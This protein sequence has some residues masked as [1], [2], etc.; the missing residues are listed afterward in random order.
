MIDRCT[1]ISQHFATVAGFTGLA[2]AQ[3]Q[4]AFQLGRPGEAGLPLVRRHRDLYRR[5]A[6]RLRPQLPTAVERIANHA[7][8]VLCPAQVGMGSVARPVSS[9]QHQIECRAGRDATNLTARGIGRPFGEGG[10]MIHAP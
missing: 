6:V 10:A 1:R 3:R 9:D 5:P 4:V 7:A 2:N 8:Q